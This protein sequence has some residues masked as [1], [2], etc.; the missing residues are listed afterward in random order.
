[1]GTYNMNCPQC[2]SDIILHSQSAKLVSCNHCAS[3]LLIEPARL[4]LSDIESHIQNKLSLLKQGGSFIWKEQ[5]FQAQGFIQLKHDEGY[6]K[7][8][9]VLD[10]QKNSYWLSEEDENFFL[11]QDKKLNEEVP[12]WIT[13]QLNTQLHLADKNWLVTEKRTQ[14]YY[15]LQG[16]LP[17]LPHQTE[18]LYYTYLTGENAQTLVLIFENNQ[19]RS[20]EG[21]WLDPFEIE[22]IQRQ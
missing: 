12:P 4:Q 3:T 9:W 2:G 7:E 5:Q 22:I 21:N 1:M 20:R 14:H 15:G 10:N 13:L 11:I 18:T 6:R 19:V 16:Q 8:W 17:Y